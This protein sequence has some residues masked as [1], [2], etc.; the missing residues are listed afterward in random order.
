MKSFSTMQIRQ[1]EKKDVRFLAFE[2]KGILVI[3]KS[4][5]ILLQMRKPGLRRARYLVSFTHKVAGEWKSKPGTLCL[6]N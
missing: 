6:L 1:G 3:T 5:F 2:Q 4:K